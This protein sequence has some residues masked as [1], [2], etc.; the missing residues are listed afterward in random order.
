MTEATGKEYE[1]ENLLDFSKTMVR[2]IKRI[3]DKK[4]IASI[5]QN[6]KK[7]AYRINNPS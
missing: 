3:S 7:T 1:F 5:I 6:N 2:E 4:T